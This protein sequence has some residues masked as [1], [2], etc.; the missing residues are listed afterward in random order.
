MHWRCGRQGLRFAQTPL[1]LDF[2]HRGCFHKAAP[3]RLFVGDETQVLL[4]RVLVLRLAVVS[5]R[6][7]LSRSRRPWLRSILIPLE[8]WLRTCFRKAILHCFLVGDEK[9]ALFGE[10]CGVASGESQPT[11]SPVAPPTPMIPLIAPPPPS[12]PSS[13]SLKPATLPFAAFPCPQKLPERMLGHPRKRDAPPPA[14]RP[15][16]RAGTSPPSL[17]HQTCSTAEA[18]DP[19]QERATSTCIVACKS[20]TDYKGEGESSCADERQ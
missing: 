17:P 15:P 5:R 3:C 7:Q 8:F 10:D 13:H 9:E 16:P 2:W 20:F 19:F 6:P 11:P 18:P 4:V 14:M 1:T 12:D